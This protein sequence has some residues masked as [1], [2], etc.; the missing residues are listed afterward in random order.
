MELL[1]FIF[2]F[3]CGF[4]ATLVIVMLLAM[5]HSVNKI[6]ETVKEAANDETFMNEL[7]KNNQKKPI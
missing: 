1:Y 4:A 2:G 7:S 5:F 6:E 3:G